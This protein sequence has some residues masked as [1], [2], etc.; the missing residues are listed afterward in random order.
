MDFIKSEQK[1]IGFGGLSP[2]YFCETVGHTL[3][4][5]PCFLERAFDVLWAAMFLQYIK[6]VVQFGVHICYDLNN[7][8]DNGLWT[9]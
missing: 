2:F 4:Q 3:H 9:V 5:F 6:F 1:E 8:I 7:N